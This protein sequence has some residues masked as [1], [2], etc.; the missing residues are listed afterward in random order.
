[1]TIGTGIFLGLVCLSLV[2]LY[3]GTKDR[4]GWE[5]LLTIKSG[6]VLIIACGTFF[7]FW[8]LFTDNKVLVRSEKLMWEEVPIEFVDKEIEAPPNNSSAGVEIEGEIYRARLVDVG[9][10]PKYEKVLVPFDK[11]KKEY[12]SRIVGIYWT[13]KEFE[14]REY[15]YS[16]SNV[17][18][19]SSLPFLLKD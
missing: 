10:P 13:G 16:P 4:W 5:R 19:K 17:F 3:L 12:P 6:S 7:N 11:N 15:S 8:L 18:G 14:K 9:P 1:M 2:F